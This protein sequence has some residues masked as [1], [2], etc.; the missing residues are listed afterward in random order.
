MLSHV[1]KQHPDVLSLDRFSSIALDC[2]PDMLPWR[3]IS[4]MRGLKQLPRRK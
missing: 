3:D 1:L 4:V 2:V